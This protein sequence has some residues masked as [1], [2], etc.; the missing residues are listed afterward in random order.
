MGKAHVVVHGPYP[1]KAVPIFPIGLTYVIL[2]A[3]LAVAY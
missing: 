1:F 2:L 3:I